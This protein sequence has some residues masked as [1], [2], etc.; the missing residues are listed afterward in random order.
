MP[1]STPSPNPT[2]PEKKNLPYW[3]VPGVRPGFN[4]N[5]RVD[6]HRPGSRFWY[7]ASRWQ[8]ERER[9]HLSGPP[10]VP[11]SDP[12]PLTRLIPTAVRQFG[13][14]S[15]VAF[16]DFHTR[17][18]QIV[19]ADIAKHCHPVSLERGTLTLS[20]YG[21]IWMQTLH[22]IARTTLLKTVQKAPYGKEIKAIALRPSPTGGRPRP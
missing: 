12:T 1:D 7:S 20:V 8:T 11:W 16:E 2:P 14:G 22:R 6:G 4:A 17:W 18:E 9:C 21:P 3:Q 15:S 13:L 10:Q 5:Q 19:G